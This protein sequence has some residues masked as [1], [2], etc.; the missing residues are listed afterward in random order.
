M[1]SYITNKILNFFSIL[2]ITLFWQ[3]EIC[4]HS[5]TQEEAP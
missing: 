4:I 3:E 2:Q 5:L 1:N